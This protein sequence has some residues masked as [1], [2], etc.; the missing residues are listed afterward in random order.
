MSLKPNINP[1]EIWGGIE[2]TMNR[3]GN[4][5]FNQVEKSGHLYR[6]EDLEM[7]S[8][9]GIKTLRYPVLWEQV[10][11]KGLKNADWSWTDERL[12]KLKELGINIIAG[13]VHHG[14]G[15]AYTSLMDPDFPKYLSEYAAAVSER[16]SWIKDFTPVNEPLTTARFSG[17]YGI[18]YPHGKDDFTFATCFLTQCK[19]IIESMKEIRRS[20]FSARLIQTEDMGKTY[21]TPLLEYQAEFEN[22]RR[23]LTFDLLTGKLMPGHPMWNYLISIGIKNEALEYFQQN[24]CKPD[25]LGINHYITSERYLDH[26][27]ELYPPSTYGGNNKEAYAD[28]EA[29]RA[30]GLNRGGLQMVLDEVS[31]RFDL[32]IALTEIH[33]GCTREEQLRWLQQSYTI[34][35]L[36]RSKGVNIKAITIWSL[37]G[38]FNWNVL[39]TRDENHYESGAFDIRSS[40]RPKPTALAFM[41]KDLCKGKSFK[42]PLLKNPG[43]WQR[44]ERFYHQAD[45]K[46]NA[47]DLSS[48]ISLKEKADDTKEGPPLIITGAHGTLGKAFAR[49]SEIRGLQYRLLSREEMDIAEESSVRKSISEI[50]PWAVINAAGFVKVDLAESQR[51]LCVRENTKGP[52][53]VAKVCSELGIKFLTFSSDLIFNGNSKSPYLESNIAS[54][55]NIYGLSKLEGEIKVFSNNHSALVVR[56]SSFFGPWDQHNFVTQALKI[57]SGG[58]NFLASN[59]HVIS[60][61]YVPDLVNASL[62]LLI[63]GE[64]GIW[65]LSNPSEITWSEFA[66][67]VA[68]KCGLDFSLVKPTPSSKLGYL[69]ERPLYSALGSERGILLPQLD[70]AINRYLQEVDLNVNMQH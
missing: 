12:Y 32:P 28:V 8:E 57:I 52:A 64:T 68:K 21:S 42:S 61:T 1:L 34:V 40:G 51:D 2:C 49:L 55:L 15:P 63:D 54:P 24:V 22:E 30:S 27:L 10:A 66:I 25:I 18:W 67:S 19:G 70:N 9:L 60:P 46:K 47:D 50:N 44:P 58:N 45:E 37:L 23:W 36:E 13:L 69:A 38:S 41:M 43:W 17:L 53:I 16:Y 6:V 20:N 65:H 4:I 35:N 48:F 26:R 59:D 29:V 31:G 11:P 56:T 14:S 3:V 39:L 62:D 5:Y 7:I 33:I